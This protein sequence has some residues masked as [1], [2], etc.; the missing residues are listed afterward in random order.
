MPK[1]DIEFSKVPENKLD[2]KNLRN[3]PTPNLKDLPNSRNRIKH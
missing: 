2:R 1:H 3:I